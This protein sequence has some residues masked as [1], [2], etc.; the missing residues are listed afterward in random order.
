[1][2]LNFH[3]REELVARSEAEVAEFQAASNGPLGV[4]Q[5]TLRKWY[6]KCIEMRETDESSQGLSVES[7][8]FDALCE[9]VKKAETVSFFGGS[10]LDILQR[11]VERGVASKLQVHLQV[12]TKDSVSLERIQL[13]GL[14]RV[15]AISLQ[16]CSLISSMLR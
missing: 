10:S 8:D 1:M 7:L 14:N 3:H 16:I 6:K 11:F 2:N 13:I 9:T 5:E 15:P 12:V 4:A